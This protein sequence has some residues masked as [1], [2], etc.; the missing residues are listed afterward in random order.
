MFRRL[1]GWW[2]A[3]KRWNREHKV[4]WQGAAAL[5]AEGLSAFQRECERQLAE[6]LVR[7]NSGVGKREHHLRSDGGS[8][9]IVTLAGTQI[10]AWIYEDG[11]S[12]KGPGVDIR[13]EEWNALTPEALAEQIAD[14]AE[15]IIRGAA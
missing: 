1:A 15:G 7:V 8:D 13:F 2:S 9:L 3:N 4:A 10:R 6:R 14:R 11:A 12:L 5:D